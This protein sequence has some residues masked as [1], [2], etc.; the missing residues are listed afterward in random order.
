MPSDAYHAPFLYDLENAHYTE[1]IAFYTRHARPAGS[2]LELGCGNGRLT[3]ALARAG[4]RVVGVDRSVPMLVSLGGRMAAESEE[5]RERVTALEGDFTDL[6]DLGTFPLVLL[7]FNALHHARDHRDV[8]ALLDGVRRHLAPGGTFLLDCY[9]PDPELYNRDPGGR[10]E[11]RD[12]EDPIRKERLRSWEESWYD[13]L[14][15]V[16]HVKYCYRRPNGQVLVMDLKLRMF[17]HAEL[18]GLIDLGGFDLV[19]E[20]S[21]FEGS[22]VVARSVKWVLSLR[23]R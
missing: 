10:Y 9:L 8:L 14:A 5:V 20:W 15:Q 6:P 18:L 2:V 7:P 4:V 21:D 3:S 23:P 11:Y 17:G 1:D 13:P 22:P 19:H 16:H 12:F